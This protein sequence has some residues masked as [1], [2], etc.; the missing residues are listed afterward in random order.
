MQPIEIL[1]LE[2]PHDAPLELWLYA[3]P[4]EEMLENYLPTSHCFQARKGD[5]IIGVLA[6]KLQ[7]DTE[8]EIMNLAVSPAFQGQGI[9][10]RLL[11]KAEETAI[12]L[13]IKEMKVATGNSSPTPLALY[14]KVGFEVQSIDY[15]YFTRT[16]PEPI[17]DNGVLCEDQIIL[18]KQIGNR[19]HG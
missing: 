7:S 14:Q 17:W 5:R 3:D 13:G 11:Q 10:K 19:F 15:G 9:A 12:G 1:P 18:R 8:A 16:Y 2:N 6:M 4:S